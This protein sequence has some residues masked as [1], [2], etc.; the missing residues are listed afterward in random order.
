MLNALHRYGDGE[1]AAAIPAPAAAFGYTGF[2]FLLYGDPRN[3][4][5]P[6]RI[7]CSGAPNTPAPTRPT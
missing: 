5:N 7:R 6:A 3:R 1:C 2:H 4:P